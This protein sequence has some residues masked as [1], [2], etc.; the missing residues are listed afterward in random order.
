MS[1]EKAS[2]EKYDLKSL[3]MI[4]QGGEAEI[5]D[6]GEEKILRVMR[7][8][9]VK[10]FEHEK[11][12][13][14]TLLDNNIS[15]PYVYEYLEIDGRSAEIMQKINGDT[16]LSLF[17]KQPLKSPSEIKR[18]ARMH[19]Q[20]LDINHACGLNSIEDI[21]NYFI[22]KPP[23]IEKKLID[24][25]L[26]IF[27]ELPHDKHLCHGDFHPGNI[28]LQDGKYYIIDWSGAYLSNFVSDIAHTY[29]LMK[30]I[31][32]IPGMSKMQHSIISLTGSYGAKVYLKE[33]SKIKK[34]DLALFSKWTVVMSFLRVYYGMASEKSGRIDYLQK[35]YDL[36]NRNVD[37]A[38]WYKSI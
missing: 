18:M 30:H 10:Q 7:K 15:V 33:V 6:I 9:N 37:A 4:A 28:M 27:E 35:C 29:L 17:K 8:Q 21:I 19:I 5:Y 1:E 31:P 34:V 12:L 20:I 3:K 25:V 23:L 26:K 14:K 36:D 13:F 16:M 38:L 2:M 11:K 24:F 32:E 22:S